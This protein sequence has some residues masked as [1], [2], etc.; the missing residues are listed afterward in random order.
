MPKRFAGFERRKIDTGEAVINTLVGGRGEPLLLLHGYPQ[1]HMMWHKVAPRLAENFTVVVTDLRGYGDSSRPPAGPDHAGY[2]KRAMARDQVEVMR[3]LGHGTFFLA[4]HDRGARVS[5]QMMLDHPGAIR[6]AALLDI[7]S[8]VDMYE[9]ADMDFGRIYYHWFFFIQ[10]NG[11]PERLIGGAPEEVVRT[12]IQRLSQKGDVFP[13][14][15]MA[16]YVEKFSA[17]EVIHATCED[18]RAGATLDMEHIRS[19]GKM[20]CPLLVLWGADWLRRQD[21]LSLWRR[22]AETVSGFAVEGSG[23]YIAE[24]APATTIAALETFFRNSS[25]VLTRE[26][27]EAIAG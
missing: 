6:R 9:R 7:I 21:V 1:T 10:G 18:Y 25:A 16:H 26:Q 14:D 27:I 17:P 15:V 24:E 11:L 13:E 20:T 8:T 23:H 3:Q 19:G 4:G 22:R 5:H 2:S 12:F